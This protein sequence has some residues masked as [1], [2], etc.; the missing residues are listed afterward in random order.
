VN[1]I[2]QDDFCDKQFVG[3]QVRAVVPVHAVESNRQGR[4]KYDA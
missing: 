4:N 1:P 3:V 2:D